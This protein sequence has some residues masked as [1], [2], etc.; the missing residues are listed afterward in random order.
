MPYCCVAEAEHGTSVEWNRSG[1]P[2]GMK[3]SVGKSSIEAI[4]TG[5]NRIQACH[6]AAG[7][8]GAHTPPDLGGSAAKIFFSFTFSLC[9]NR[10]LNG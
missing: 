4:G 6:E 7:A 5:G 8:R 10:V 9:F 2:A 3:G 1:S